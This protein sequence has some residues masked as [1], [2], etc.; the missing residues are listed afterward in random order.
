MGQQPPDGHRCPCSSCLVPTAAT[1][2][3][4][5]RRRRKGVLAAVLVL[6]SAEASLG[7]TIN[8]SQ[9]LRASPVAAAALLGNGVPAKAGTGMDGGPEWSLPLLP[10]YFTVLR[11]LDSNTR[12]RGEVMLLARD[13]DEGIEVK[14][15]KLPLGA[16]ASANFLPVEQ[17]SLVKGTGLPLLD[18]RGYSGEFLEASQVAQIMFHSLE[19]QI[20]SNPSSP[21]R[22][23]EPIPSLTREAKDARGRRYIR[24]AYGST[25]CAGVPDFDGYCESGTVERRTIASVTTSLQ[26]QARTQ[27]ERE[28]MERGDAQRRDFDVLWICSVSAPPRLF[29]GSV[30][31]FLESIVKSFQV[32]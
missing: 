18:G 10:P 15:T 14:I 23:F 22:S 27:T 20:A 7:I 31:D 9:F 8:R 32:N 30:G 28:Q 3:L 11:K 21:L 24:Y 13:D 5:H 1:G 26:L 12:L 29:L 25:K 2:D 17:V 6:L 4:G 19:R 16:P